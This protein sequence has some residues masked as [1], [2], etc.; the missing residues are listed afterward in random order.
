MA[1][2][3]K[4]NVNGQEVKCCQLEGII[5]ENEKARFIEGDIVTPTIEG[6]TFNY[7]KWSLSGTHLMLV[8]AFEVDA[9]L[10]LAADTLFGYV[11][12]P[13]WVYNK[14]YPITAG[15]VIMYKNFLSRDVGGNPAYSEITMNL[16]KTNSRIEIHNELAISSVGL[17]KKAIR[18]QYD[19]LI[20]ND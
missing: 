7:A 5:D 20:D 9:N 6:V 13:D 1:Y 17:T 2:I 12:L 14:I 19:L 11:V 3:N 8:L 15:T 16:L 4:I 10:T 18:I